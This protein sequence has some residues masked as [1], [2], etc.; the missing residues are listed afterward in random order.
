MVVGTT[1]GR[2]SIIPLN[3]PAMDEAIGEIV[4]KLKTSGIYNNSLI[5]FTTDNGG[6][7][8][9]GASNWPLRGNKGSYYEGGKRS[10]FVLQSFFDFLVLFLPN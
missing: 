5:V 8:L 3:F 2:F 7:A 4:D 6:Q 1:Q 9:Y 10:K